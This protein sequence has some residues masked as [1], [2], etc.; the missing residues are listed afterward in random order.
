MTNLIFAAANEGVSGGA[1]APNY[2]LNPSTVV[3]IALILFL[4]LVYRMGW[5]M[6]RDM[7]DARINEIKSELDEAQ[8]LR[9]EAQ[10]LLA[11]YEA[12][13]EKALSEAEAIVSAAQKD[14]LALRAKGEADLKESLKRREAAAKARIKQAEAAAI[15]D[16]QA[17]AAARAITAAEKILAENLD[18]KSDGAL[19]DE[20]IALIPGQLSAARA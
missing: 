2:F 3:M 5:P 4:I 16:A 13:H 20:A 1:I 14:A 9:K 19:I 17:Q 18:A 11:E 8:R 15:A 7:L 10:A 6:I 12:K